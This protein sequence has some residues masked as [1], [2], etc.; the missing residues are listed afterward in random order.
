MN[1]YGCDRTA[2]GKSINQFGQVQAH[3]AD[4]YAQYMAGRAYVYTVSNALELGAA[5]HGLETD[6]V[7]L[8]CS[9]MGKNVADRAIQVF[10]LLKFCFVFVFVFVFL[11][12]SKQKKKHETRMCV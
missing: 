4:S 1:N 2:F 6:A 10:S 3:L 11:F 7:K 9:T 12:H 8:Y 5:G